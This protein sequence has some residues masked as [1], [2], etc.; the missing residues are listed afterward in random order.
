MITVNGQEYHL[1]LVDTAGQVRQIHI[2][3]NPFLVSFTKNPPARLF[4]YLLTHCLYVNVSLAGQN[5]ANTGNAFSE[6]VP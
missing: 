4:G 2:D 3:K 5:Q 1:Q 6:P